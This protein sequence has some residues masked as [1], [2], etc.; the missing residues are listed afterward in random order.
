MT[1]EKLTAAHLSAVA[2]LELLCFSDPWSEKALEL[3]VSDGA[4]GAVCLQDGR[5]MAYGGVLW[6]P[7]EGQITNIATHPDARRRGMG[8]AVLEHLI[9]EACSRGC[10]QLSLE[11]RVSNIGAIALY[12]RYGFLKMGLRR[13]FYKHPTEDAYVMCLPLDDTKK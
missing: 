2:E 9:A 6:A 10:D 4:Y 1:V 12:E 3:L 11:A 13:G 5:V 7:D 8:A